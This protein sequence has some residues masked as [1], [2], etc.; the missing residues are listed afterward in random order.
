VTSDNLLLTRSLLATK[1]DI[2]LGNIIYTNAASFEASMPL[3]N[4]SFEPD[5]LET[6]FMD[7]ATSSIVHT[8]AASSK[9]SSPFSNALLEANGLVTDFTYL[10]TVTSEDED[11]VLIA[12]NPGLDPLQIDCEVLCEWAAV[13]CILSMVSLSL[14]MSQ[15]L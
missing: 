13:Y 2:N 10:E 5:G 9:A 3:S 7:L 6:D 15:P 8:D 11:D 4:V 1:T 14:V 12:F